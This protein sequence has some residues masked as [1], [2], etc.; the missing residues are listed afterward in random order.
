MKTLE[1]E[2]AISLRRNGQSYKEIQTALG[3]SLGSLSRWL[4]HIELLAA[5][6]ERIHQNQL[7]IRKRF[8]E[9]NRERQVQRH[10]QREAAYHQCAREIQELTVREL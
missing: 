2:R 1:K 8:V 5:H 6:R 10:L 4:R 3:V 7:A 9:S